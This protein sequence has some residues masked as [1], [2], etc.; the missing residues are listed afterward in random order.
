MVVMDSGGAGRI[1]RVTR[2][3]THPNRLRR[4]DRWLAAR[5]AADL[6]TGGRSAA[7]GAAPVVIDL[8][9]GRAPVTVLELADRLRTIVHE[10]IRVVGMEIDPDRVAAAK[11]ESDPPRVEFAQ[12]GFATPPPRHV[13]GPIVAIRAANVLRQYDE[14]EVIGAW[15]AMLGQ[16]AP[17]GVLQEGT[18]DELGRLCTWVAIRRSDTSAGGAGNDEADVTPE[19]LTLAWKWSH[20]D[21]PS[22][23]AERL[24]KALIH[25]N[26]PG[27]PIHGFLQALDRAWVHQVG[28][29]PY[30]VR[31]RWLATARAI[32]DEGWPIRNEP[33]RWRLG[34]ITVAWSAVAPQGSTD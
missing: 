33:K 30:G 6:K 1:D 17:G 16:L 7:A 29:A 9:F 24:P 28:L 20:L 11:S 31:Q 10:R 19:S 13:D 15:R 34:E 12:G 8:G 27:E 32:H 23:I 4:M 22:T 26:V 25:H 14:A 21:P 18:C 2:G 5:L 3:T